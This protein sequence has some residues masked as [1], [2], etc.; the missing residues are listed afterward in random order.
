VRNQ[1][2]V[3]PF[4]KRGIGDVCLKKPLSL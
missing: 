2:Q 4:L 1:I 3:L